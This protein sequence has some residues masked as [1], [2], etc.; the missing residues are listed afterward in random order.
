MPSE[1]LAS[2]LQPRQDHA[3]NVRLADFS[4]SSGKSPS[5]GVNLPQ[6]VIIAIRNTGFLNLSR[7]LVAAAWPL[8]IELLGFAKV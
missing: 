4:A 3:P 8:T 5:A 7:R 6:S 2:G 1:A